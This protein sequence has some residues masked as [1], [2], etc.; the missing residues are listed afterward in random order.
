VIPPAVPAAETTPPIGGATALI[1]FAA[2]ALAIAT[3]TAV[4]YWMEHRAARQDHPAE[5]AAI[6]SA[7]EYLNAKDPR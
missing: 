2:L 7:R 1:I 3:I 4:G 5:K 6:L